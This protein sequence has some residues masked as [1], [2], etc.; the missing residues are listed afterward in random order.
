MIP[1]SKLTDRWGRKRCFISGLTLYG[2]GSDQR[3]LAEPRCA[4]PRQLGVRGRRDGAADPPRLHPRDL[5]VQRSH[6]PR[7]GLRRDQRAG[8]HRRRRRPV[9]RRC[10]HD[11]DQLA[12]AF[13][14]QALVVAAIILLSRRLVDPLAAR[15][16]T[17]LRRVGRSCRRS[18]CSASSSGSSRPEQ[19]HALRRSSSRRAVF[20]LGVLP[21]HPPRERPEGGA[22]LH[23]LFKNRTCNLALVTQNIQWLLLMGM[24]FVVSVFLQEFAATTRSRPASSSPPRRSASSSPPSLRSASRSGTRSAL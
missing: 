14:F 4:D 21:L 15:S 6:L 16:D 2:S 22:A 8:R 23:R 1:C 19:Q 3:D 18:G 10:D 13:V 12:A 17:S 9:D 7:L 5:V 24:S 20:L 11:R